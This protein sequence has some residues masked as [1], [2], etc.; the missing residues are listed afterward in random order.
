MDSGILII[1][2]DVE[3]LCEDIGAGPEGFEFPTTRDVFLD[4]PDQPGTLYINSLPGRRILSWKGLIKTDIQENRRL[5]AAACIPGSLK[6]IQFSTCDGLDL[7]AEIEV[8]KLLAPYSKF[9]S[10]Y[11]IEAIAP[12][13]RF[14]SQILNSES[15]GITEASGGMP[16]PG[17]IP[18]PIPGGA[19]LNFVLTNF[20]NYSTKPVF[21]IRGPGTNFIVQNVDT[22]E[23]FNLNLT[24]LT[25]ETVVIDT[26]DNSVLKGNADFF[27][28]VVRDPAGHWVTLRPGTNR[29][30][31]NAETGVDA[32]TRLT[33]DWRHAYGGV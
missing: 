9:R 7:Q 17:A 32:N 30:V 25:N 15:T 26:S 8:T 1:N 33:V 29:L 24:L 22:G 31:F 14:Y 19:S 21:T 13:F 18:A 10:I 5:L 3:F 6:T 20:G 11:M 12:D 28:L 2:G 27:G 23:K 4:L 16:I